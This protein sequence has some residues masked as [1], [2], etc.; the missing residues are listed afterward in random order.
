LVIPPVYPPPVDAIKALAG[1]ELRWARLY[2]AAIMAQHAELRDA[3]VIEQL[4]M[5]SDVLV[6][7][8]AERIQA[9]KS[10]ERVKEA[11]KNTYDEAME[12][13]KP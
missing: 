4:T 9:D 12:R 10:A 1:D 5:D 11:E 3:E 13:F 6:R 7:Q 2:A 8:I